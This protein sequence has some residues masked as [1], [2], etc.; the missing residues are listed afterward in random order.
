MQVLQEGHDGKQEATIIKKFEN[1]QLISE[2]VKSNVVIKASSK[3]I[4][5]I[6]TSNTLKM[7]KIIEE[8][9]AFVSSVTL[10]LREEPNNESEKIRV[11]KKDDKVFVLEVLDNWYKIEYDSMQGY[12][13]KD[14]L[15]SEIENLTE[16]EY[17]KSQ[18][19]N[20]LAIDMPLNEPSYLSLEQFTKVLSGNG[21]DK[22]NIFEKNAE[23]FYYLEQQYKIN[24]IFVAAIGIHESA[25][26]TSSL[27]RN[28][29]N[30][31]GYGANDR[32]PYGDAYM[33]SSYQE[34]IDLVSRV[35]VKYYINAPGTIIYDGTT[36]SGKYYNG[37]NLK[38]VNKVYA[39]DKNW[40]NAV[41]KWMQFLYNRL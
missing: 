35:L 27:A 29:N 33:F 12:V 18:L 30:L 34:G 37:S 13:A 38:G 14:C 17:T 11:L 3:K 24:G 39:S 5:Q 19:L 9:E 15:K 2:E 31:F 6:G 21:S 32:N 20:K 22:N 25:W 7:S 40:A 8:S 36:A 23:Y 41:Y 26:G 16:K 28:K 1:D 4:V 10:N